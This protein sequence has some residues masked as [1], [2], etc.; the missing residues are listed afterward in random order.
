MVTEPVELQMFVPALMG[1]MAERQ[2]AQHVR[3]FVTSVGNSIRHLPYSVGE[4]PTG[5]AWADK[6]QS[7]DT[8][9]QAVEC[10]NAGI[11]DRSSGTCNCFAGFTGGACQRSNPLS[12]FD[13][14]YVFVVACPNSCSNRG[15]CLTIRDVSVY[16]GKD[17]DA[18]VSSAGDGLGV[19]YNNWDARSVTLC[20]C[21]DGYF[22]PDC[23]L[24]TIFVIYRCVV[25]SFPFFL[26]C[27]GSDV[28]QGG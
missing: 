6:A 21:D 9:H 3:H 12:F 4:C 20:D 8:A 10:S 14:C 2:I 27:L 5:P 23:S 7:Q 1:G 28:S 17:Y 26:M 19:E 11:C 18:Q 16:E 25:S 13:F 15:L 22:G 24:G